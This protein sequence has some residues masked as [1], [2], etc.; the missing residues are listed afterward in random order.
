MAPEKRHGALGRVT[1]S[2]PSTWAVTT[3]PRS[4]AHGVVGHVDDAPDAP[5][6]QA[7]SRQHRL[8]LVDPAQL[9]QRGLQLAEHLGPALA[10]GAGVDEALVVD[11][12]GQA[13]RSGTGWRTTSLLIGLPALKLRRRT[14]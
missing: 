3:A 10:P 14:S 13:E 1:S 4:T 11:Q 2:S 7:G 8:D 5:D 9:Q 6:G 12:L